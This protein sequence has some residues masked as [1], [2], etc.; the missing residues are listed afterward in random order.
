[1]PL[2]VDTVLVPVDGGAESVNATEYAVAVA[3][4]YDAALH[5]LFVAG[6]QV[7]RRVESGEVSEDAVADQSEAFADDLRAV[8]DGRVPFDVSVALGFSTSR[9]MTH[10]GSVILDAADDLDADFLVVPRETG[11]DSSAVLE[12]AAEYVLL[13]ASQPVLSV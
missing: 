11:D 5:A 4:K 1:M 9:K 2:D 6:E 10:P 12:K 7:S 3:E 13:Y 8:A